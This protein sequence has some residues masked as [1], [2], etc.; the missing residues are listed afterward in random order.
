MLG[1]AFHIGN[2][3]AHGG[4]NFLSSDICRNVG[5]RNAELALV[6]LPLIKACG[7]RFVDDIARSVEETQDFVH[8]GDRQVGYGIE[9][10]CAVAPFGKI[11]HRRFAKVARTRNQIAP[12]LPHGVKSRHS[13]TRI[14]VYERASLRAFGRPFG[15]KFVTECGNKTFLYRSKVHFDL[16]YAEFLP[17][18]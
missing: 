9:I 5:V 14:D 10:V 3:V 7:R 4:R 12:R 6:R 13:E 16:F 8:L 18:R 2:A 11:A 1:H 15:E 17:C